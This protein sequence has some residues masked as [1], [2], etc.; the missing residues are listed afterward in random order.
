MAGLAPVE[1]QSELKPIESITADLE[2]PILV[3]KDVATTIPDVPER[4][5]LERITET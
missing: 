1:I 4:L 5:A 2:F 3:T